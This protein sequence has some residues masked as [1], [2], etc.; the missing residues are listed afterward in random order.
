MTIPIQI[1]V[2]DLVLKGVLNDTA[3]AEA[4]VQA[5][6]VTGHGSR[7]GQEIYFAAPVAVNTDDPQ[8]E[9]VEVGTLAYWP[10]GDAICLFW[11]PTPASSDQR[12]CA[13]SP[14]ILLGQFQIDAEALNRVP[15]GAVIRIE[16]LA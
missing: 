1:T 15:N 2:A 10:P 4:L 13:A 16:A 9:I 3:S 7:W 5:L 14:V 11:G 12:P 8:A 6:P